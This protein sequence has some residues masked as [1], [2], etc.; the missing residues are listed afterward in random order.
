MEGG[1]AQEKEKA[2]QGIKREG[3]QDIIKK[4][5]PLSY[6]ARSDNSFQTA[7]ILVK[8]H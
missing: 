6:D 3:R 8:Q 7:L 1:L 5:T 4:I 2:G